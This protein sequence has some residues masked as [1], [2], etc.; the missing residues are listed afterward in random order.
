[1]SLPT[2]TVKVWGRPTKEKDC[3]LG[4]DVCLT[5]LVLCGTIQR[6]L[7]NESDALGFVALSKMTKLPPAISGPQKGPPV[8]EN[9][10]EDGYEQRMDALQLS[11]RPPPR[12]NCGSCWCISLSIPLPVAST[13]CRVLPVIF[14]RFQGETKGS[15]CPQTPCNLTGSHPSRASCHRLAF[16]WPPKK[17]RGGAVC[18]TGRCRRVAGFL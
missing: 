15:S 12:M 10:R 6:L 13:L 3:R 14:W 5:I 17:E 1:M 7:W 4:L 11:C 9:D 18:G 2:W 16:C 8:Q